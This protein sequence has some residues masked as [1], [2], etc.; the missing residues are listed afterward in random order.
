MSEPRGS[1][2]LGEWRRVMESVV[3]SAT[4]VAGRSQ[5]PRDLMRASQRQLEL[6]QEVVE[7]ERRLQRDLT[8]LVIAPVDAVFDL[9]EET[10]QTLRLQAEALESAG[11][12]LEDTAGLMK[13]QSER[14]E[15]TVSALRQPAD[16]AKAAAG[17][18]RRPGREKAASAP[19]PRRKP[20]PAGAK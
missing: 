6:L 3:S 15:R 20:Q 14:F 1:D 11:R 17:V 2:L 10:G 8:A 18:Q 19:K 12:A 9:L 4:S 7:R 16:L 13:R 5:I